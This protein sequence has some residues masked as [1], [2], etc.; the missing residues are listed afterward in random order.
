[1]EEK[2][3]WDQLG[4]ASERKGIPMQVFCYKV[5]DELWGIGTGGAE[6]KAKICSQ[7]FCFPGRRGLCMDRGRRLGERDL[8]NPQ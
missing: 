7:P 4:M 5:G 8:W 3:I 2:I 1:M 6:G